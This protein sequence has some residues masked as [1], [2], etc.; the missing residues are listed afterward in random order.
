MTELDPN[1]LE[2]NQLP[3]RPPSDLHNDF[4][5]SNG[6]VDGHAEVAPG[7]DGLKPDLHH[8]NDALAATES[9]MNGQMHFHQETTEESEEQS[10]RTSS[11]I[12]RNQ[13]EQAAFKAAISTVV[14]PPPQSPRRR[15][16][17]TMTTTLHP[18]PTA[19]S[20]A[21]AAAVAAVSAPP[22]GGSELLL[23]AAT[24]H[25]GPNGL[26]NCPHR[27]CNRGFA[28]RY[29]LV[30]HFATHYGVRE[31]GCESCGRKFTRRYDLTRHQGIK[32]GQLVGSG[33]KGFSSKPRYRLV[34]VSPDPM[35]RHHA[36]AATAMMDAEVDDAFAPHRVMMPLEDD[37][38]E[39]DNATAP[40]TPSHVTNTGIQQTDEKLQAAVPMNL[41]ESL[42]AH[43]A[44][45]QEGS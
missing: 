10:R 21:V 33:C 11:R 29:N 31:W 12:R 32:H 22:A 28:R 43:Q 26:F 1:I 17:S 4:T 44:A 13:A 40:T 23:P 9:F 2:P 35:Q 15:S 45:Q 39:E 8:H 34:A 37:T 42:L 3:D 38:E 41:E 14:S 25:K 16:Q 27:N 6:V 7:L 30:T 20:V 5:G 24:T 19:A 36:A 18:Q